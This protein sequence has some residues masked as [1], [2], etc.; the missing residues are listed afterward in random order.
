MGPCFSGKE[1]LKSRKTEQDRER[2]I[3]TN[4]EEVDKGGDDAL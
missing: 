2:Y 4:T 1:R 3:C